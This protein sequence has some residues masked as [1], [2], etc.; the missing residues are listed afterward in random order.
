V[1]KINAGQAAAKIAGG[2]RRGK[3]TGPSRLRRYAA[4]LAERG[5][6]GEE[7]SRGQERRVPGLAV[8]LFMEDHHV[9]ILFRKDEDPPGKDYQRPAQ[10]HD[11]GS[12]SIG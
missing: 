5:E 2:G 12:Q 4:L 8:F 6:G 3:S 1:K 10:T 11:G 7:E 9:Q